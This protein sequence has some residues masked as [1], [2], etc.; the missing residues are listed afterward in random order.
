MKDFLNFTGFV[1]LWVAVAAIP[2]LMMAL[3]VSA[4]VFAFPCL[5]VGGFAIALLEYADEL[6]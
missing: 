5:L 1:L 4:L 3:D 6:K 2:I